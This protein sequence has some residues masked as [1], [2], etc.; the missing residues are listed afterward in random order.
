M[1]TLKSIVI[2]LI[3]IGAISFVFY[4][5]WVYIVKTTM[6]GAREATDESL[7]KVYRKTSKKMRLIFSA[8]MFI[9]TGF[10]AI[11]FY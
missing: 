7:L 9:F 8:L 3:V 11:Y 4:R 10:F 5:L 6:R 2:V 1:E